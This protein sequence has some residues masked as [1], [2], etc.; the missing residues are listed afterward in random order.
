MAFQA[1]LFSQCFSK[2][3]SMK[4]QLF[5]LLVF[6]IIIIVIIIIIIIIITCPSPCHKDLKKR[7][8]RSPLLLGILYKADPNPDL[9]KKWTT[10]FLKSG[11]YTRFCN[12]TNSRVLIS[13]ITISFSKS[14]TK[15]LKSG[16]F[17]LKFKDFYFCTKLCNKNNTRTLISNMTI[18]FF[19][20]QPKVDIFG[21]KYPNK[22]FLE[23]NLG[24]FVFS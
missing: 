4:I 8:Q 1:K 9:Q 22:A 21:Q 11:P 2:S 7:F 12:Q 3:Y 6:P 16:I 5:K 20:F 19:K 13:N 17:G 23:P 10:D 15:I 24:S 18:F 14:C